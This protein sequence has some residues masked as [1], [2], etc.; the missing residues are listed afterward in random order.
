M[1]IEAGRRTREDYMY[2]GGAYSQVAMH[3]G[4]PPGPGNTKVVGGAATQPTAGL[5]S[6][7]RVL[8]EEVKGDVLEE[9][10][11]WEE[12]LLTSAR[13]GNLEGVT[14]ALGMDAF[15]DAED[16]HGNTAIVLAAQ[17]G[18]K[19]LIKELMRRGSNLNHQNRAGCTVLHYCFEYKHQALADYLLAKG[20]DDG[21]LNAE[22]LTC[23]EGLH[24]S[25]VSAL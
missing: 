22:G 15:I 20:A 12:K 21:L 5:T 7:E 13:N 1:E 10:A 9:K 19:L 24:A 2:G 23:Y 18:N 6:E 17:Q 11:S 3:A 14:D 8:L 4:M 16:E 25:S